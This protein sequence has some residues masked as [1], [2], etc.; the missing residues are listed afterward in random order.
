MPT[1]FEQLKNKQDDIDA[2]VTNFE[3][4]ERKGF[5]IDDRYWKPT[6]DSTGTGQALIRFLP[7]PGVD[8]FVLYYNHSFQNPISGKWYIEKC[9]TSIGRTD[10]PVCSA[11]SVLWNT[12]NET[13]KSLASSRKRNLRYVSNIYVISD[14]KNPESEGKVFLFTYGTKIY[15][16][17]KSC[18]KPEF[19]DQKRF[20]PFHPWTGANFR[21]KIKPIKKQRSYDLSTFDQC[22]PLADD[23]TLEKILNQ[24]YSLDEFLD[25]TTYK[26]FEEL[27]K[28]FNDVV[29]STVEDPVI[30]KEE[31]TV[32]NT[33]T[34]DKYSKFLEKFK[35]PKTVDDDDEVF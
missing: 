11:N 1:L 14:P 30:E 15:Q 24:V 6:V 9:P 8:P 34:E 16:M 35:D 10:C 20:N 26:P 22:G 23:E 2:L 31:E 7:S 5:T 4:T 33:K 13:K 25:P 12:G 3:K 18:I 17:I 19:A 21:M 32:V 27:Q 28:R 29:N